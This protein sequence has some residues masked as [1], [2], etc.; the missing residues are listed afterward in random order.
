MLDFLII[1]AVTATVFAAL[2]L[3][4]LGG[5]ARGFYRS[6]MGPM[7]ADRF[8][9]TA[10]LLF[11]LGYVTGAVVFGALADLLP[12]GL[13]WTF[14]QSWLFGLSVYGGY[15]LTNRATLAR[16]PWTLALTDMA[17]GPLLTAASVTLGVYVAGLV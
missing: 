14:V 1:W 2:D 9:K 7:I 8:D 13:I 6:R 10:A 12:Q 5:I 3:I 16:W 4:W 17:W 11:Y 15:N